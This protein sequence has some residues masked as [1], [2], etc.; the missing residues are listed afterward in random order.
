MQGMSLLL[1]TAEIQIQKSHLRW[2]LQ[3]PPPRSISQFF[4]F[5]SFFHWWLWCLWVCLVAEKIKKWKR[6]FWVFCFVLYLLTRCKIWWV[7][8]FGLEDWDVVI[9]LFI[10]MK[11]KIFYYMMWL[12]LLGYFLGNQKV[13]SCLSCWVVGV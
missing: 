7:F 6:K 13:K 1:L 4:S 5:F 12:L 9:F 3:N 8:A 10:M 11:I 2:L